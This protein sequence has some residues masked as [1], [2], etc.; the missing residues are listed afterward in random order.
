MYSTFCNQI[1]IE[2][3]LNIYSF[4]LR[5]TLILIDKNACA[6]ASIVETV[7]AG[8]PYRANNIN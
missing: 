1:C 4:E 7:G 5:Y 3:D 6:G 2:S 8:R